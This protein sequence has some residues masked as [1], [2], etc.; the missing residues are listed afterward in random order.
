VRTILNEFIFSELRLKHKESPHRYSEDTTRAQK[1]WFGLYTTR[2]EL[3]T[4]LYIS[5][6]EENFVTYDTLALPLFR[7][8]DWDRKLEIPK[9]TE[10]LATEAA[11]L[12][13]VGELIDSTRLIPSRLIYLAT[14]NTNEELKIYLNNFH[15][16]PGW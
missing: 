6:K 2:L 3:L 8:E 7:I 9:G 16:V 5:M 14:R 4:L 12:K 10:L 11:G 15:K 1:E 13:T